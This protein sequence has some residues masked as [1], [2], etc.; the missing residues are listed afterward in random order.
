MPAV[1]LD[2]FNTQGQVRFTWPKSYSLA[3]AYLDQL[4]RSKGMDAAKIAAAR[5][6]LAHAEQASGAKQQEVLAQLVSRLE[7]AA[8]GAGDAAR[9]RTLADAVRGLG[10]GPML[11]RTN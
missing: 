1:K 9:V 11:A 8:T 3:R 5:E 6:A 7:L 2:Y 4:E 10:S